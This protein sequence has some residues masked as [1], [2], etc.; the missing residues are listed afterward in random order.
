[1]FIE[2]GYFQRDG[3]T[4]DPQYWTAGSF[5]TVGG[6]S[7]P[8]REFTGIPLLVANQMRDARY[9][10]Q[11]E[12]ETGIRDSIVEPLFQKRHTSGQPDSNFDTLYW[13]KVFP[14]RDRSLLL[15][16]VGIY[17]RSTDSLLRSYWLLISDKKGGYESYIWNSAVLIANARDHNVVARLNEL[18]MWSFNHYSI[19]DETFWSEYVLKREGDHYRYLVPL[20]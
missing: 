3:A 10:A 18:S 1:L 7:N 11:K 6:E 17:Q 9:T 13:M 14:N 2:H 4:P 8:M 16:P 12:F 20:E 19:D 15:V 5:V